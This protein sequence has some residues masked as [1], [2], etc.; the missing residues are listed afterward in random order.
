MNPTHL[1]LLAIFGP[2]NPRKS[3]SKPRAASAR[4]LVRR[5]KFTQ[6]ERHYSEAHREV[7]GKRLAGQ[8]MSDKNV[9]LRREAVGMRCPIRYQFF[10]PWVSKNRYRIPCQP[11]A[12]LIRSIPNQN[13]PKQMP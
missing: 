8:E 7:K 6:R 2:Q 11:P 3:C 4:P 1:L 5:R 10:D 9:Q 13:Y 12:K